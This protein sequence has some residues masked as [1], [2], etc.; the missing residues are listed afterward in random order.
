M[1]ILCSHKITKSIVKTVCL[2]SENILHNKY[3]V[4]I[5]YVFNS[6]L[7]TETF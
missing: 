7:F 3:F 5:C 1:I 4:S 6:V 2:C